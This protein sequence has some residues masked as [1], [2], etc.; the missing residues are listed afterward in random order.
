[1]AIPLAMIGAGAIG[2][3]IAGKLNFSLGGG[4]SDTD[5]RKATR[6]SYQQHYKYTT[7]FA[8]QYGINPLVALGVQPQSATSRAGDPAARALG[9]VGINIDRSRS[10]NMTTSERQTQQQIELERLKGL[11]LE[12]MLTMKRIND[13]NAD[14]QPAVP[15]VNNIGSD[16]VMNGASNNKVVYP[17]MQK[18]PTESA[19]GAN[20]PGASPALQVVNMPG[21]GKNV[22]LSKT[23]QEQFEDGVSAELWKTA[24]DLSKILSKIPPASLTR[25]LKRG[26]KLKK[27]MTS[28]GPAWIPTPIIEN[29]L[30]LRKRKLSERYKKPPVNR[31]LKRAKDNIIKNW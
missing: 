16:G 6:D 13:F 31:M 25:N 21:G 20:E 7:R 10:S 2:N 23:L 4:T 28:L 19:E 15:A 11:R 8:R 17:D 9:E 30:K 14:G 12:N 27:Y 26:W 5:R 29:K 1:M 18:A 3:K 22:F 24:F